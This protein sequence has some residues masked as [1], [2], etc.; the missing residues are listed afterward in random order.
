MCL[1]NKG[2]G[3]Q[4]LFSWIFGA[5]NRETHS[6]QVDLRQYLSLFWTGHVFYADEAIERS[7]LF[8]ILFHCDLSWILNIVPCAIQ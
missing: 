8:H 1:V 6:K 4:R 3:L 7:P 2:Q 5:G